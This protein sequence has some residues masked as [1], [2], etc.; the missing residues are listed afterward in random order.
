VR[1]WSPSTNHRRRTCLTHQLLILIFSSNY[2]PEATT[3]ER[4][5]YFM[6]VQQYRPQGLK[7]HAD[8]LCPNSL[9]PNIS[10]HHFSHLL[11]TS[12][13]VYYEPKNTHRNVFV[14]PSTNP[15]DSDEIWHVLSWV[16]LPY[17]NFHLAWIMFLH[18]PVKLSV[19]VL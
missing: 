14:I 17:N 19:R 18:H 7:N 15:V 1:T 12:G 8:S 2:F 9:S 13:C 10:Y 3:N 4:R 16:N 6:I 5:Q 11:Q